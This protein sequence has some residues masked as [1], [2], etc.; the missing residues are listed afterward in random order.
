MKKEC[1]ANTGHARKAFDLVNSLN[2]KVG[3]SKKSI[4]HQND[5]ISSKL[6]RPIAKPIENKSPPTTF[7][8][9]VKNESK[10][11]AKIEKREVV[12]M[13]PSGKKSGEK[14]ALNAHFVK[15]QEQ[16]TSMHDSANKKMIGLQ[17]ELC[18]M[19]QVSH[20]FDVL[21]DFLSSEEM[22]SMFQQDLDRLQ[23]TVR[24]TEA[25]MLE[26]NA[27]NVKMSRMVK[28]INDVTKKQQ[29][30]NDAAMNAITDRLERWENK[31]NVVARSVSTGEG[32]P[33]GNEYELLKGDIGGRMDEICANMEWMKRIMIYLF[34]MIILDVLLVIATKKRLSFP[35]LI[36]TS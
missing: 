15:I 18:K 31:L 28:Q 7:R 32:K 34:A 20:E 36:S 26:I 25:K 3:N 14:N 27:H 5:V 24:L 23:R 10:A 30:S 29:E 22:M 16:F 35:S 21:A 19:K 12:A 33:T 17:L 2:Q 13:L 6:L 9:A 11:L 8:P 4:V 1:D